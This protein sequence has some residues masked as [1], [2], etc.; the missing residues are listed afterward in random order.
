[1]ANK[2]LP[3]RKIKEALRLR[4]ECHLSLSR[5][6]AALSV[7][8]ATVHEYM[9]RAKAAQLSWPLPEG[10]DDEAIERLLFPAPTKPGQPARIE[11][12]WNY[13]HLEL[14]RKSV[15]LALLWEEFKAETPGGIQYSQFC[16]KY[17]RFAKTIDVTMRQFHRAGEK[18][19]VD[20]AGQTVPVVDAQTGEIRQAQVFVAVLGASNYT[21]AE[22]TWS[23]TS[24]DWQSS[25]VRA[26]SFFGGVPAVVVPDNLK[27]GVTRPCRYEPEINTAYLNLANHYGTAIIP[28]RVRKPRD[29]A[30][31]EGAVLLAERWIL[32]AL[33][34][35]TFF[36]LGEVN[37]AIGELLE[38]LN[39]RRFK[40]F[41]GSRRTVFETI[42]KPA[43]R[44]LPIDSYSIADWKKARVNID[45]HIELDRHY[46]SVPYQLARQEVELRFSPLIVEIFW[47]GNRIA[48][49]VRS[50]RRGAH[51]TIREHMPKAHQWYAGMT[52]SKIKAKAARIGPQT[53]QLAE[54]I[55][56]SRAH[57]EQ[58]YRACLGI[59]RLATQYGPERLEAACARALA[60][61]ARSYRSVDSIL[62]NGI[63]QSSLPKPPAPHAPIQHSNIRGAAYYKENDHAESTYDRE[64]TSPAPARDGQGLSGANNQL[65]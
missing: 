9:T 21:F 12:D 26:F 19:F 54:A 50:S 60:I 38:R 56:E 62:K 27:S 31:A 63:E 22:A 23:Q 2:R 14:R 24:Y 43:L 59:L 53:I 30:K 48:S 41:D 8:I 44:P 61:G 46:Y 39:S 11:P 51:T 55:M 42:D 57:P 5:I 18:L 1:M 20:Y 34:N 16:G 6:A 65:T 58:G 37:S 40:K 4:H 3:M 15:T 35:R 7:S 52:P 29:K 49:H 25:H 32:A 28:T 13:I 10:L 64:I 45:Y 17:R 36:S 47:H 33:R